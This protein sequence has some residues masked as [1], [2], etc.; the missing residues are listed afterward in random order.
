MISIRGEKI[1]STPEIQTRRLLV[2]EPASRQKRQSLGGVRGAGLLIVGELFPLLPDGLGV[3]LEQL[4]I[5]HA[6]R[7][8]ALQRLERRQ[9]APV[10]FDIA[11]VRPR[12]PFRRPPGRSPPPPRV[13][14]LGRAASSR[15]R[16]RRN[17]VADMARVCRRMR[18]DDV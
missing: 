11:R 5:R 18:K 10:G 8:A 6:L 1:G 16:P 4:P 17:V 2:F 9:L 13:A 15:S 14:R 7:L 3:S 12:R